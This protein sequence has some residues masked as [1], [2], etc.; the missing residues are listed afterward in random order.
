M[1]N[2]YCTQKLKNSSDVN[3]HAND[4]MHKKLSCSRLKTLYF[5]FDAMTFIVSF[6]RLYQNAENSGLYTNDRGYEKISCGEHL[7]YMQECVMP[8]AQAG[9]AAY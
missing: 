7:A 8:T 5:Q 1:R 4:A 6:L 3:E 2:Y 9:L